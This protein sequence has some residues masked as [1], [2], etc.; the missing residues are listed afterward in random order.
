MGQ[1]QMYIKGW[2]LSLGLSSRAGST[3]VVP[4]LWPRRSPSDHFTQV[5]QASHPPGA[6][7]RDAEVREWGAKGVKFSLSFAPASRQQDFLP[8]PLQRPVLVPEYPLLVPIVPPTTLKQFREVS[9]LQ[10]IELNCILPGPC[11]IQ[12]PYG[13]LYLHKT[14]R[15]PKVLCHLPRY[16]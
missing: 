7:A 10:A 12:G 2:A 16:M 13:I 3:F 14:S 11:L 15:L 6:T 9:S 8:F 1:E 4:L 5:L